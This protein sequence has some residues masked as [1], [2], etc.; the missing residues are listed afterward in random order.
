[1]VDCGRDAMVAASCGAMACMESAQVAGVGDPRGVQCH[2]IVHGSPRPRPRRAGSLVLV[3]ARPQVS[4]GA[5]PPGPRGC[6]WAPR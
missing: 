4:R 1:M 6:S 2:D 3:L 5:R